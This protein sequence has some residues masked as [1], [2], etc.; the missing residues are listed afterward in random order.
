MSTT[1]KTKTHTIPLQR[2]ISSQPQPSP[3]TMNPL[4]LYHGDQPFL[5][6]KTPGKIGKG[7]QHCLIQSTIPPPHPLLQPHHPMMTRATALPSTPQPRTTPHT[8]RSP[9]LGITATT[10]PV[11]APSPPARTPLCTAPSSP[12]T[13]ENTTTLTSPKKKKKFCEARPA[14]KSPCQ[15]HVPVLPLVIRRWEQE[16][17]SLGLGEE[18]EEDEHGDDDEEENNNPTTA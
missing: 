13:T 1:M 16:Q 5:S 12:L 4:A 7:Q 6:P 17:R 10:Y 14:V 11:Q 8:S 9:V 3:H 18:K 2:R 15:V